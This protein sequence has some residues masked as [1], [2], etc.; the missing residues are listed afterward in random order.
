MTLAVT[1]ATGHLGRL[2]IDHLLAGGTPASDIV[3][4]ARRP[5]AAAELAAQGVVVRHF[6]YNQPELLASALAG[7]DSLLLVSGNEFGQRATQHQAVIVAAKEAGVGRI[8][9]TS[10]PNPEDSINPVS[11]EH[12]A[13]ERALAA[14]GVPHVILRNGWYH[15]NYVSELGSAAQ[16]GA[17]LTAAGDGR[18]ASA[19]RSDYAHAAAVVL[20]SDEVGRIYSLS[21]DVAWSFDDLAA[22]LSTVL[23]QPVA[24]RRV[25][26]EEKAA[27]LAG[28]GLDAGMVG[29]IVGVDAAI[30]AGELG[31]TNGE[32]SA[33]IGHPT[34]P[35]VETLRA[36]H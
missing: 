34:S 33:L 30:A 2:A 14:S 10:A 20:A 11:P 29:F 18:V 21:G 16:S 9:Y 7:V 3:A 35:I 1:G 31:G 22:D 25:S 32:L 28:F 13:T 24:V 23:G 5:E 17:V 19:S 36:A 8:V 4:L 27:A 26:G 15:E 6:D 12:A